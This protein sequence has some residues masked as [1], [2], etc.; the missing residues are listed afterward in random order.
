MKQLTQNIVK[1]TL[2]LMLSSNG[3]T[4]TL[5]VKKHL[6]LLDYNSK[7]REIHDFIEEIYEEYSNDYSRILIN[8]HYYEYSLV[9]SQNIA[10]ILDAT[11]ILKTEELKVTAIIPTGNLMKIDA[12]SLLSNVQ[13]KFELPATQLDIVKLYP[14][15][16]DWAV[17]K[18]GEI[19]LI[20]DGSLS[21]DKVR[22]RYVTIVDT[23]RKG[24]SVNRISTLSK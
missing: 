22:S 4:T 13:P 20:F 18:S 23:D 24:I 16:N 5:D 15:K 10:N 9:V 1:L 2:D 14:N 7:Q 3:T 17:H 12:K 19:I 11:T 21:S 6:K 8:N